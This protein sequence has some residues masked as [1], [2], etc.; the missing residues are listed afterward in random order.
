M[1]ATAV[2]RRRGVT[3]ILPERGL[4]TDRVLELPSQLSV[5]SFSVFYDESESTWSL[6]YY[7]QKRQFPEPR[8]LLVKHFLILCFSSMRALE[9]DCACS[10]SW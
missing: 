10:G 8:Q 3:K 6:W 1:W 7:E 5:K 9:D 4:L 2:V